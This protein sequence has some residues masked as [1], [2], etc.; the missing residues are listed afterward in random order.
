MTSP[1]ALGTNPSM[2]R[3]VIVSILALPLISGCEIAPG[4]TPDET[5]QVYELEQELESRR[6]QM[7]TLEG[8]VDAAQDAMAQ[9]IS[10]GDAA[11]LE[12]ARLSFAQIV[13]E[14]K[15]A[16]TR[17]Q[18]AQE[19]TDAIYQAAY[20]RKVGPAGAVLELLPDGPWK[21]LG[22]F[23]PQ[24]AVWTMSSRSRNRL[25]EGVLAGV[26]GNLAELGAGILKSVG[27]LHSTP[28]S[29]VVAEEEI[30]AKQAATLVAKAETV[31]AR[32]V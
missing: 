18:I 4:F 10:Q 5:I 13:G 7:R 29:G 15:I 26:K 8:S 11:Q 3:L 27:F 6:E 20:E 21:I 9:A 17:A 14:Y 31:K 16:S 19:S 28:T 12:A 22:L 24:L 1:P 2:K 23:L 32:P 25:K 30:V